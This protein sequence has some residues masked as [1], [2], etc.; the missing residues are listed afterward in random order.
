MNNLLDIV[1]GSPS[2]VNIVI[3]LILVGVG[4]Y[5]VNKYVTMQPVV[6]EILNIVVVL[7]LVIWLLRAFGI[8]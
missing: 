2:V 1:I 6:K 7:L 8:V 5:L 3:I 4:L